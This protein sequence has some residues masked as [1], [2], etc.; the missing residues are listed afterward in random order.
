MAAKK[1]N[2]DI[3]KSSLPWVLISSILL[4]LLILSQALFDPEPQIKYV[5]VP[6]EKILAERNTLEAK[7]KAGLDF[8]IIDAGKLEENSI[9]I[10]I[11]FPFVESKLEVKDLIFQVMNEEGF[12]FPDDEDQGDVYKFTKD[13]NEI[14]VVFDT[15]DMGGQGELAKGITANLTLNNINHYQAL[16]PLIDNPE[17]VVVDRI[18]SYTP[19]NDISFDDVKSYYNKHMALMRWNGT[20]KDE[21]D[22][23]GVFTKSV[24][25]D[26]TLFY[27]LFDGGEC[28]LEVSVFQNAD[29]SYSFI[30]SHVKSSSF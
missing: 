30:Q 27:E 18:F 16:V 22:S 10:R 19:R 5:E 4:I 23:Y 29:G 17:S 14:M 15:P 1:K 26:D 2:I 3:S 6:G 20:W 7:V 25:C 21:R 8:P 24:V 13:E 9:Q 11:E 28:E 12:V